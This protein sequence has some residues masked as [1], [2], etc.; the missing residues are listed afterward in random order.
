ME[1]YKE[2]WLKLRDRFIRSLEENPKTDYVDER[3]YTNSLLIQMN[4]IESSVLF[5]MKEENKGV[6]IDE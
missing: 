1:A 3:A 2:M 4:K 6:T 5:A